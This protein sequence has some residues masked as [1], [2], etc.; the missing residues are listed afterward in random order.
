MRP[1]AIVVS[2]F[3]PHP[4]RCSHA[5]ATPCSP[6]LPPQLKASLRGEQL[7]YSVDAVGALVPLIGQ[8]ENQVKELTKHVE[9]CV[10]NVAPALRPVACL[11]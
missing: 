7:P 8:R 3:H 6:H 9:R 4:H 10:K 2:M 11:N 1:P 5:R